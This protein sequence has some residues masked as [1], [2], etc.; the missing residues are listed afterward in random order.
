MINKSLTVKKEYLC[1][2]NDDKIKLLKINTHC[3]MFFVI[4]QI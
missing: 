3:I 1:K 2:L 4:Y